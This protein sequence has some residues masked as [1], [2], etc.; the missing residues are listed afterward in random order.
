MPESR[1]I[2]EAKALQG[3]KTIAVGFWETDDDSSPFVMARLHSDGSLDRSFNGSGFLTTRLGSCDDHA[4]AVAVQADGKIVV[5][6]TSYD[7]AGSQITVLRYHPDGTLD[8]DFGAGGVV[9]VKLSPGY[10]QGHGLLLQEDG[11]LVVV[12]EFGFPGHPWGLL[13]LSGDGRLDENFGH[14]LPVALAS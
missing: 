12:A 3:G 13:R 1:F 4:A 9:R 11:S 6:G 7:G 10:D 8:E 2:I 14:P 5:V